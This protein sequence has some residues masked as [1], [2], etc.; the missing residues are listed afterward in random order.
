MLLIMMMKWILTP[1]VASYILHTVAGMTSFLES[2]WLTYNHAGMPGPTAKI[3]SFVAS[4]MKNDKHTRY[5]MSGCGGMHHNYRFLQ[6]GGCF[7]FS[8]VEG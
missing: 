3:A 6:I 2:C 5:K 8:V 1:F 7:P 4:M